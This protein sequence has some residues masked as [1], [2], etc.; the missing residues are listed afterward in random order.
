[1]I[2]SNLQI[3]SKKPSRL[4]NGNRVG[5]TRVKGVQSLDV[6]RAE[7]T[8]NL[9]ETQVGTR[10]GERRVETAQ[11]HFGVIRIRADEV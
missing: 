6:I 9:D 4:G 2:N 11:N 7:I 8:Q 10:A 3:L 1:M 5:E